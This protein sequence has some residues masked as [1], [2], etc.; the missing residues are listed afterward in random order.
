MYVVMLVTGDAGGLQLCRIASLCMAGRT[1]Q[2]L[3]LSG[4]RELGCDVMVET[5]DLPAIDRIAL[6]AL[7]RR[8][9]RARMM[10]IG[11]TGLA[12]DPFCCKAF[13]FVA[14]RAGKGRVLAEQWE[15]GQG[16]IE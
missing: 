14:L 9:E 3:V 6:P 2:T 10:I 16:M 5:P 8:A 4:Q 11:M 7:R 13:V 15:A 1:D 12:R